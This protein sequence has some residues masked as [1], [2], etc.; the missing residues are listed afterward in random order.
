MLVFAFVPP[1]AAL[2]PWIYFEAH[3]ALNLQDG[4][5]LAFLPARGLLTLLDAFSAGIAQRLLAG[6]LTGIVL[7]ALLPTPGRH[8][9]SRRVALGLLGGVLGSGLAMLALSLRADHLASHDGLIALDLL[10]GAICGVLAASTA[11]RLLTPPD[12]SDASPL[13]SLAGSEGMGDAG[14]SVSASQ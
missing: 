12:R 2:L 1:L 11:Y 14:A 9:T 6:L 10:W 8:A 13:A 5:V 3:N 4:I 7:S